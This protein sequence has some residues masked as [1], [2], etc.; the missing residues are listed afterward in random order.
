MNLLLFQNNIH[1]HF[2]INNADLVILDRFHFHDYNKES[3]GRSLFYM[4]KKFIS[5]KTLFRLHSIS[6]SRKLA[7]Q[8]FKFRSATSTCTPTLIKRWEQQQKIYIRVYES[9]KLIILT[10][11]QKRKIIHKQN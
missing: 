4:I 5:I 1:F 8:V 9:K 10:T 2:K 6:H 7:G 3:V 11:S